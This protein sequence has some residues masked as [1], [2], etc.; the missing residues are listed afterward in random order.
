M[1]LYSL[2]I[3]AA[4]YTARTRTVGGREDGVSRSSDGVLDI[5]FSTPGS[6][7]MGT[8]PEQLLAAAWSASFQSCLAVAANKLNLELPAKVIISAEVTLNLAD[9]LQV[10]S[11]RLT[12]CLSNVE[13]AIAEALIDDAYHACPFSKA[14]RGNVDVE[15]KLA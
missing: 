1:K 7:R 9:A 12:I 3:K 11:A 6:A 5:C 4:G 14:T 13:R 10:L 2:N 8:N 15:I